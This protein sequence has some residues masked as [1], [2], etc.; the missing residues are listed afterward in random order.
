MGGVGGRAAAVWLDLAYRSG[1]GIGLARLEE[2]LMP[3]LISRHSRSGAPSRIQPNGRRDGQRELSLSII[4]PKP[5]QGDAHFAE[6]PEAAF[7]V[8]SLYAVSAASLGVLDQRSRTSVA[9]RG[10]TSRG[11]EADQIRMGDAMAGVVDHEAA[12][13]PPRDSKPS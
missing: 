6:Q 4:N 11:I 8:P 9:H 13:G 5:L 7:G 10:E 12:A 3:G 1:R 2:R